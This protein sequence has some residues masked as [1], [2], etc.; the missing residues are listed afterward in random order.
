MTDTTVPQYLTVKVLAVDSEAREVRGLAIPYDEPMTRTHWG[1]GARYQSFNKGSAVMRENVAFYFNHDHLTQGLPIGR[2]TSSKETEAGPE[3]VLRFSKTA[4]GDEVYVLFQDE[5]ITTFSVGYYEVAGRYDEESDTYLH[6]EIDVFEI[7]GAPDAQFKTAKVSEVLHR[8][9]D[10]THHQKGSTTMNEAQRRR[11]AELLG[12]DNPNDTERQEIVTLSA[13]AAGRPEA[14]SGPSGTGPTADDIQALSASITVLERQV[15]T[16][17]TSGGNDN[18][19]TVPYSSYGEFLHAVAARETEAMEFLAYVGGTTDDLGDVL[20]DSW[21]GERF[22]QVEERRTVL[23]FFSRSPLPAT[24]MGVEYGK[25]LE[26]TTQVG[27]QAAQGDVLPYGKIKFTTDRA[28]LG[29]YGGWGEMSFQ[30]IQRSPINVVERFFNAL[31][32]RYAQVTEA[33]V[34]TRA[35]AAGVAVSGGVLDMGTADGWTRFV[36]RAA[37]ELKDIGYPIQGLLVGWDVFE[38]LAVLR[39]GD[40][41]D[42]PRMLDRNTGT[43]NVVGLQGQMFNLPVIPIETGAATNVIRAANSEAIRTYEASGAPFRLQDEDITNLTKAG[44]IY[45]YMADA[46]EVPAAVRKPATA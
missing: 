36:I 43:L 35:T 29:T 26:D 12:K 15:A 3:V 11:L 46:T 22:R 33:A 38:N 19:V 7:S 32:N 44:S 8:R 14:P 1:T 6:D 42:A 18:A 24:G 9:S 37:K 5:V 17:G 20:K 2:M 10:G 40:N 16:L 23:N 4:K 13:L 31:L 45:G 39:D 28:A 25:V 34:N 30:E 21:V 27:K 41:A